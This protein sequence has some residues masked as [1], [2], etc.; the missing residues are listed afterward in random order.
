MAMV[1]V[2]GVF[3]TVCSPRCR[4]SNRRAWSGI[5]ACNSRHD[6]SLLWRLLSPKG[7]FSE[8]SRLVKAK[9]TARSGLTTIM[10]SLHKTSL[11]QCR[12]VTHRY[13]ALT[14]LDGYDCSP[15]Q[16][17]WHRVRCSSR[18]LSKRNSQP[19]GRNTPYSRNTFDHFREP[20]F[21]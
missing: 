7:M 13:N 16:R 15:S 10:I 6:R 17:A 19:R 1:R 9:T 18:R 20:S 14:R 3:R 5:L 21:I 8:E 4:T 12:C 2:E 11:G